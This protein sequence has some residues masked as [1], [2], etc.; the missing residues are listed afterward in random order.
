[1]PAGE[2][3]R[4]LGC[5]IP[6]FALSICLLPCRA[7]RELCVTR[8]PS[9]N[10]Q[11]QEGP[12]NGPADPKTSAIAPHQSQLSTRKTKLKRQKSTTSQP[13]INQKQNGPGQPMSAGHP[14]RLPP[15]Q[16]SG[17]AP[18]PPSAGSDDPTPA[19]HAHSESD[20]QRQQPLLRGAS[21]KRSADE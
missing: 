3:I 9:V 21:P 12:K 16:L 2:N 1:M 20:A 5:I 17:T 6:L 19:P 10:P 4:V 11:G 14:P 7:Q 13:K 18:K 8:P 15:H